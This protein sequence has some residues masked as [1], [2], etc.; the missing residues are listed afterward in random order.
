[1][2]ERARGPGGPDG[3]SGSALRGG[4]R[5][6]PSRPVLSRGPRAERCGAERWEPRGGRCGY[7]SCSGVGRG[8]SRSRR[9]QL[10]LHGASS[11]RGR[12]WGGRKRFARHPSGVCRCSAGICELQPARGR[13]G[14]RCSAIQCRADRVEEQP[15]NFNVCPPDVCDHGGWGWP[16][17]G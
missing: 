4:R 12:P 8:E 7:G 3:R 10:P 5:P 17:T 9:W 15:D 13:A 16:G 14:C 6:V 2:S 11:P 1:M